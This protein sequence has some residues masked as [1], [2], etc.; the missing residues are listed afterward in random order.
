MFKQLMQSFKF[1]FEENGLKSD[2]NCGLWGFVNPY[3]NNKQ[4]KITFHLKISKL[5]VQFLRESDSYGLMNFRTI[6]L[7]CLQLLF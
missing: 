5:I 2:I 1:S 6:I 3:L 7:K 4:F